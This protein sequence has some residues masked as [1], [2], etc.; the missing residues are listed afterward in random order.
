VV[1]LGHGPFAALLV[2]GLLLEWIR[3]YLPTFYTEPFG[4]TL[5]CLVGTVFVSRAATRNVTVAV[6][7]LFLLGV[8]LGARSGPTLLA[9]GLGALVIRHH[10]RK[11]PRTVLLVTLALA[12]SALLPQALNAVYGARESSTA[13]DFAWTAYGLS[14]GGNWRLA[15]ETFDDEF[16]SKPPRDVTPLMYRRAWENVRSDPQPLIRALIRNGRSFLYKFSS[17]AADSLSFGALLTARSSPL[18]ARQDRAP[19][20]YFG[21]LVFVGLCLLAVAA[22]IRGRSRGEIEFWTVTALCLAGSAAVVGSTGGT[23]V[24]AVVYPLMALFIGRGLGHR[25]RSY[26]VT[27]PGAAAERVTAQFSLLL[28]GFLVVV[29]VVGPSL[30]RPLWTRPSPGQLNGLERAAQVVFA[31]GRSVAVA[32]LAER[33]RAVGLG[34]PTFNEPFFREYLEYVSWSEVGGFASLRPPFALLSIYDHI[35]RR[36]QVLVASVHLLR[37]H[38]G[39]LAA[40]VR[41]APP[42]VPKTVAGQSLLMVDSWAPLPESP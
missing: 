35:S 16:A 27:S 15:Q 12:S 20:R 41:L 10:K 26:V 1:G 39:F 9:L 33:R 31:P 42:E 19:I 7:A 13:A 40:R 23:R 32:V 11:R 30:L 28:G 25:R 36:Q 17:G 14:A 29:A 3:G 6:V 38:H 24:F 18:D 2:F 8:A 34:V 22:I 5:G 37:E 21:W 4:L